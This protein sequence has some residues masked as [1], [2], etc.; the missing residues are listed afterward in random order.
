M[1]LIKKRQKQLNGLAGLRFLKMPVE[2]F[3]KLALS[4]F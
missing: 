4:A 3:T 2:F 1:E